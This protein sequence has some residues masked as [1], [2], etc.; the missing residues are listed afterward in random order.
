MPA[1][2]SARAPASSYVPG[3]AASARPGAPHLR[4]AARPRARE[5]SSSCSRSRCGRP[6]PAVDLRE[7]GDPPWGHAVARPSITRVRSIAD[8]GYDERGRF[9]SSSA[10]HRS[11]ALASPLS[12][13]GANRPARAQRGLFAS[14]EGAPCSGCTYRGAPSPGEQQLASSWL[15]AAAH[16]PWPTLIGLRAQLREAQV[17]RKPGRPSVFGASRQ[18]TP[19]WGRARS[20]RIERRARAARSSGYS[21]SPR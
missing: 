6:S 19:S 5:R 4:Q 1:T 3:A 12:G 9:P 20:T 10:F 15:R 17:V 16:L 13:R 2:R 21:F 11:S 18:A 8:L 7:R 14:L